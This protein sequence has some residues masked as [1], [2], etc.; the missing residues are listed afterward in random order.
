MAI[1][2][3]PNFPEWVAALDRLKMAWDEYAQAKMFGTRADL[4][5]L[6]GRIHSAKKRFAEAS[7]AI[8]A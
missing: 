5:V 1:E 6:E 7:D 4:S 3:H 8:D 2:D